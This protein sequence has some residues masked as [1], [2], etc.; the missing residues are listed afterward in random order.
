M[1]CSQGR[2]EMG[3]WGPIPK[4]PVRT[5]GIVDIEPFRDGLIDRRD[6]EIAVVALPE[7]A[8]TGAIEAFHAAIE[9]RRP[10]WQHEEHESLLLTGRLELR[11]ELTATIN[12]DRLDA[13]RGL[14]LNDGNQF[15]GTSSR[16]HRAHQREALA[17]DDVNRAVLVEG[18]PGQGVHV[19]R[20][21]L[22]QIP[23]GFGD[24]ALRLAGG[25][26]ARLA[27]GTHDPMPPR[28]LEP[29]TRLEPAQDAA[30]G[31]DR[32][33]DALLGQEDMQFVLAPGGVQEAQLP[34]RGGI[35]H[36]PH[37]STNVLGAAGTGFEGAQILGIEAL[38]PGTDG[39]AVKAKMAGGGGDGAGG[40]SVQP[41]Q[42]IQPHLFRARQG[43]GGMPPQPWPHQTHR[44]HCSTGRLGHGDSLLI[45]DG[46]VTFTVP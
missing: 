11:H 41:I 22:D 25:M 12:L 2:R 24:I 44:M 34:H 38:L 43:W 33:G 37:G 16:C 1:L 28:F 23:W 31:G 21:D 40:I 46:F 19:D 42:H 6:V 29:T 20:I 10:G 17:T 27:L 35:S 39:V 3:E 8:P 14:L 15:C 9:F 13:H 5:N 18:F 26:E 32:E 4:R 30:N 36:G 7:L 45:R